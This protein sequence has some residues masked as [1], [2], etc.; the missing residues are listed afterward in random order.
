MKFNYLYILLLLILTG[1]WP[2]DESIEPSYF[3]IPPATKLVAIP[4]SIYE[5]QVYY[6]LN[7]NELVSYNYNNEWD[8]GFEGS[9]EGENIILNSADVLEIANLGPLD[10]ASTQTLP[11]NADFYFD[12][13]SG[14]AD[15]LAINGWV[16]TQKDPYEYSQ[17][18]YILGKKE[19]LDYTPYRKMKFIGLSAN[20]YT[21]IIGNMDATEPDTFKIEKDASVNYINYKLIGEVSR[22]TIEPNS[23]NWDIIFSQYSS[24]LFTDDGIATKYSVRG[25]LINPNET[26]VGEWYISESLADSASKVNSV[27]TAI[28]SLYIDSVTF[29]NDWDAIGWEWK[30]VTIDEATNTAFYKA[31]PRFVYIIKNRNNQYFK[32][33]F[34]SYYNDLG[35]KGYPRFEYAQIQ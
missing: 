27:F 14:N 35:V 26:Q 17:N 10:F 3:Y 29:K 4:H 9:A 30:E 34:T 6:N 8:L 12:A 1:C 28:D 19:G 25:A 22:K 18:L 31:D 16:D 7:T 11:P 32:L 2:E 15:S 21:F 20:S 33:H 23:N 5:Y 24:I 13:S